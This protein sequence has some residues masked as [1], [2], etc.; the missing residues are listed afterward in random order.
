MLSISRS[1][2]TSPSSSGLRE[3]A[4][5]VALGLCPPGLDYGH[6]VLVERVPGLR[7]DRAFL[8]A[9]RR[10]DEAGAPVR[11]GPEPVAV[12]GR[13]PQHLGDHDD[14]QRVRHCL[15]QIEA[16]RV[17]RVQQGVHQAP[18]VGLKGVDR[19]PGERLVDKGSQSRV[20]GRVQEQH[21]VSRPG[22]AGWPAAGG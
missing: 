9:D 3:G 7:R 1:V 21:G 10:L 11:P 2:S 13:H 4:H 19:P 14:R 12:L 22:P 18:D 6:E 16:G 5:D 17:H 15:H 8:E 20:V